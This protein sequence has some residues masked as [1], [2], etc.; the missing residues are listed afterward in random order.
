M[1]QYFLNHL[2]NQ[3][4]LPINAAF[5]QVNFLIYA[6]SEDAAFIRGRGLIESGVYFTVRLPHA[7]FIGG[8]RLKKEVRCVKI[9]K[10]S[11]LV[12]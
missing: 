5:L 6:A 1:C 2:L 10:T 7:A 3:A 11:K 4:F 8:R 12:N 9:K